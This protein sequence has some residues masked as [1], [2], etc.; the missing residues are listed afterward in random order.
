MHPR[1][2]VRKG[3]ALIKSV[4]E[5]L[6]NSD[7]WDKVLLLV[8]FDEHGGFYDHEEPPEA[9]PPGGDAPYANPYKFAFDRLGVRVPAI[10]ISA[11][12][13]KGGV[14]D[15]DAS[16]ANIVFDHASVYKTLDDLFELGY[17]TDRAN[18]ANSLSIALTEAAPRLS[19]ASA[20]PS[21]P[22]IAEDDV[23]PDLKAGGLAAV[24]VAGT[25]PV[26]DNPH[27]QSMLGLAMACD[28]AWT[29]DAAQKQAVIGQRAKIGTQAQA[30]QYIRSVDDKIASARARP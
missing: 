20:L 18:E 7:Y 24:P 17:L 12:T 3:E 15:K 25:A 13:K 9:I 28:V 16:G 22:T 11:Y 10:V 5:R 30:A 1:D 21:L 29:K 26:T 6:R 8:V 2:D 19:P 14:I 4:Y 23:F 27:L